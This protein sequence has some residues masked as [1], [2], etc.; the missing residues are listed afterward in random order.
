MMLNQGTLPLETNPA[1]QT[2]PLDTE[3][4]YSGEPLPMEFSFPITYVY[5]NG[6]SVVCDTKEEV[7]AAEQYD[8]ELTIYPR[9]L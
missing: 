3:V 5:A 8:L 4:I 2:E 7:L 6:E 1:G 9:L